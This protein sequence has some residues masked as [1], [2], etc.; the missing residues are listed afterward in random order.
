LDRLK[1]AQSTS[2]TTLIDDYI[3]VVCAYNEARNLPVLLKRIAGRP[4]LVI[5]DGSTDQTMTVL[6]AFGVGVVEHLERKGKTASLRDGLDFARARGVGTIVSLDG[7]GLP[8]ADAI[9]KLLKPLQLDDV[10]GAT[11][12]QIP[13]ARKDVAY[14]IDEVIWSV[15]YQAKRLQMRRNMDCFIGGVLLAFKTRFVEVEDMVN[16]DE[17]VGLHLKMS[18][19][20]TVLVDDAVVYFDASSSARH[21]LERRRRMLFGHIIQPST[22]APSRSRILSMTGLFMAILERPRRLIWAVPASTIELIARMQA[23]RDYRMG[24][25]EKYRRWVSVHKNPEMAYHNIPAS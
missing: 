4:V 11:P 13:W 2:G 20:R 8:E 15:L 18:G 14:H 25:Y 7:D 22:D 3:V 24:R 19:Q 10:G 1:T 17:R 6:H 9:P 5:D 16:D 23:W 21:L 12:H